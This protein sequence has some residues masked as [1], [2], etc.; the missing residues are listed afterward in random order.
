MSLSGLIIS[1]QTR[2]RTYTKPAHVIN[3][4]CQTVGVFAHIDT[5]RQRAGVIV[6]VAQPSS[7]TAFHLRSCS[8]VSDVCQDVSL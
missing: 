7:S 3:E 6:A 1:F 4:R 5:I 8:A 2:C